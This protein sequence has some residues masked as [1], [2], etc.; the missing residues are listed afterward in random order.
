MP[1]SLRISSNWSRR[2]R[3]F[4]A[5]TTGEDPELRGENGGGGGGGGGL[6]SSP[7]TLQPKPS[8]QGGTT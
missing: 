5:A 8:C 7:A 6:A 2:K 3:G 1:I 4:R